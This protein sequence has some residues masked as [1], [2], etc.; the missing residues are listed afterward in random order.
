VPAPVVVSIEVPQDRAE[1]FAVLE[2]LELHE[3]FC[4]HFLFD[5]ALYGTFG[6]A[7]QRVRARVKGANEIVEIEVMEVEPLV[8]TVERSIFQTSKRQGHGTYDLDALPDGG[9]RITFTFR[10]DVPAKVDRVLGPLVR[11]MMRTNNRTALERLAALLADDGFA[12]ARAARAA[13]LGGT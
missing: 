4:D 9:T 5:W 12:D 2:V 6:G 1:V 3:L 13:R 10:W 11:R 8:R 7:G